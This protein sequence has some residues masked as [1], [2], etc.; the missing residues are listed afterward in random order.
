MRT[1]EYIVDLDIYISTAVL[2]L[3]IRRI[4]LFAR[5]PN[6][7]LVVVLAWLAC[8]VILWRRGAVF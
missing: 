8:L 3:L 6:S 1:T 5:V 2:R 7:P 4:E